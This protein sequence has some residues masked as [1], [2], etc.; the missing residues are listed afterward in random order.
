M[1]KHWLLLL[2]LMAVFLLMVACDGD[3]WSEE[4][5]EDTETAAEQAETIPTNEPEAAS[6]EEEAQPGEEEDVE[7][8]AEAVPAGDR[9]QMTKWDL[10]TGDTPS[11]RGANIW[12]RVVDFD[13]DGPEFMGPGPVGPPFTQEDFDKM[14]ALGANYV[15]ISHPGLFTVDPP[16]EPI[17]EVETHLDNLL[18]MIGQADMFAVISYR[19]GPGRSEF[20]F[21]YGEAGD[22]FPESYV[23]DTVWE[24][25]AAQEAWIEMWRYTA[26]RYHDHPVVVGYDL[27]VEPNSAET[28]FEIYDPEEFYAAH[29]GTSY[30]WNQHYP[31]ITEGIRAVDPDTPILIGGNGYSGVAWLPYL[32]PT[33][34]PR[35]V[36]MVHQYEPHLY[37]H[38]EPGMLGG[39]KNEY[40]G[41][42][43]TDWDGVDEMVDFAWLDALLTPIDE[44][45]AEHGAP[46][47]VNEFGPQRFEPGAA[48]FM[49]DQIAA[50]ESRGINH[51]FWVWGSSW[52]AY[53]EEP[54]PFDVRLGT[55]LDNMSDDVPS[56]LL[57]VIAEYWSL[58]T[59][60]PSGVE[61]V[62]AS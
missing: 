60:R 37:T 10:W 55:D 47:A 44:F 26:E 52:P 36:Y 5:W 7:T 53:R 20:T 57:D 59:L 13:L 2:G 31:A 43:D 35:T 14:A 38:Q 23:N 4:D 46:V 8:E 50:F 49:D 28:F 25:P 3:D 15:N 51:A 22:W 1:K 9:V 17:P 45:K 12:Q 40:P 61:F 6:D 19:T 24:D 39:L 30:D 11:L 34:D 58:N 29:G 27:M 62:P 48:A 54:Q 33:D 21:Y 18:D 56:D 32:E 16:Y 42:F 41:E